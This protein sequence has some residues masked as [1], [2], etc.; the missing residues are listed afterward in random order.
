V[1]TTDK[2]SRTAPAGTRAFTPPKRRTYPR[3]DGSAGAPTVLTDV[4]AAVEETTMGEL[5]AGEDLLVF[6]PIPLATGQV[7]A[8]AEGNPVRI[9]SVEVVVKTEDGKESRI[10]LTALHG[11]WWANPPF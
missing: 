2:K 1:N 8:D 10:P 9:Q 11:A 4:S 6:P 3:I 7:V 5:P